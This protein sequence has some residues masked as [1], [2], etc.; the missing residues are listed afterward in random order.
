MHR[1][2]G[3]AHNANKGTDNANK[4]TD[5]ANKGT[6]NANKGTDNAN[7]G[8]DNAN[9]G[10]DRCRVRVT[11]NESG[12]PQLR[13][14]VLTYGSTG[15]AGTRT[16]ALRCVASVTRAGNADAPGAHPSLPPR[17]RTVL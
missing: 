1:S 12:M 13:I 9:K 16:C 10:T 11:D 5:D 6:D 17:L 4:G 8:T 3:G 2:V 14:S 7:K 15:D